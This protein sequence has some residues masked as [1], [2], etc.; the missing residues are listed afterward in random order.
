MKENGIVRWPI[1]LGLAVILL[2]LGAPALGQ[3]SESPEDPPRL[4]FRRDVHY[5]REERRVYGTDR[6]VRIAVRERMASLHL[7]KREHELRRQW[8]MLEGRSFARL[9][10]EIDRDMMQAVEVRTDLRTARVDAPRFVNGN[11]SADKR[12]AFV[13]LFQQVA[14]RPDVRD[15]LQQRVNTFPADNFEHHMYL[16]F[17]LP[18]GELVEPPKSLTEQSKEGE[19]HAIFRDFRALWAATAS[20]LRADGSVPAER[21]D[22]MRRLL[23]RWESVRGGIDDLPSPASANYLERA[24]LLVEAIADAEQRPEL[25]DFLR[26][27]GYPFRGGTIGELVAHVLGHSLV[28]RPGSG[29]HVA[30]AQLTDALVEAADDEIAVL[31]ARIETLK[32]QSPAHNA[33][34]RQRML[35]AMGQLSGSSGGLD[36][37]AFTGH[38]TRRTANGSDGADRDVD[39]NNRGGVGPQPALP[40]PPRL[41]AGPGR[42]PTTATPD[43]M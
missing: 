22:T 18:N 31:Q 29:A 12:A 4:R 6:I 26:E 9:A 14:H 17:V 23:A 5:D 35:G 10:G 43:G 34:L 39:R 41:P 28:V 36:S 3:T 37:P 19:G 20:E 32:A 15:R 24:A 30:L 11:E 8:L 27:Q 40:L 42:S 13:K 16:R 21:I 38:G 2:A 25:V 7:R 33:V 1:G